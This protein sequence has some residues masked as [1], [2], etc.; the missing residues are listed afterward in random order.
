M[1][2]CDELFSG[3]APLAAALDRN[4]EF[5]E[6]RTPL[7]VEPIYREFGWTYPLKK[8]FNAGVVYWA[9][10]PETHRFAE[11]WHAR[12]QAILRRF[13][14]H[15]D[16]PAFNST[17]SELAIQ[18]KLLGPEY[19]AMVEAHPRFAKGARIFHFFAS[20][21]SAVSHSNSLLGHLLNAYQLTKQIDWQA[22]ESAA[23]NS[24]AWVGV[25]ENIEIEWARR[26]YRQV[27]IA[28]CRRGCRSA[29]R[30]AK[31]LS[32]LFRNEK[33]PS[34]QKRRAEI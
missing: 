2:R 21:P 27:A 12:W 22:V 26:H 23:A 14:K 30:R 4:S 9:D 20:K 17:V 8:Y 29:W 6:P 28:I 33:S 16:Q 11:E 32:T 18:V 25:T 10:T 31:R 15:Y 3:G 24:D 13:G 1:H 19:N 7:W 5:P 34:K